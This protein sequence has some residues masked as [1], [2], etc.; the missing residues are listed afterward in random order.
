MIASPSALDPAD[1]PTGISGQALAGRGQAQA[2]TFGAH[3]AISRAA[4]ALQCGEVPYRIDLEDDRAVQLARAVHRLAPTDHEAG[5]LRRPNV[6][7]ASGS[8]DPELPLAA[9]IS[10]F[11]Q[12]AGD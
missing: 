4:I 3:L 2:R 10:E 8:E 5:G 1:S 7:A 11:G 6:D 12:F 9:E